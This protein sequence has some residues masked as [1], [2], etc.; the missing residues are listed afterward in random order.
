[1]NIGI[2]IGG[3]HIAIGL[4]E[5]D[6]IIEKIEIQ[7]NEKDKNQIE[8]FIEDTIV[9]NINI[10]LRKNKKYLSN[11]NKIGIA[12]PGTVEN[13]KII[14]NVVNLGIDEFN[15][16]EKI[17]KYYPNTEI[18]VKNDAKCAAIAEKLYGN[19]KEYKNGLFI[20][21]GTGVGGALFINGKLFE[22]Q[23]YSGFEIGHVSIKQSGE[24]CKCGKIGCFDIYGS[25]KNFKINLTQSLK[26]PANA[27]SYQIL[28]NLE[29][30]TTNEAQKIINEYIENL[31]IGISNLINIFEPEITVIGGSFTYYQSI[32]LE[33]LKEKI[34]KENLLFNKRKNI[35]IVA[36]KLFNDAGIIGAGS[37]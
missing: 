8:Q 16:C 28:P 21:L 31:A 17:K 7:I 9:S 23:K 13:S 18:I 1:M 14:K 6:E 37:L 29:G 33:P 20:C 25:M 30:K 34:I 4:V 3:S 22:P 2:D 35:N 27:I 5:K 32:L 26:M 36:A 10:L 11:I 19:M 15:I 24:K 12:I